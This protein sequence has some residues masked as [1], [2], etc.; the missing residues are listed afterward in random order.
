MTAGDSMVRNI[1][2]LNEATH[3]FPGASAPVILEK[4]QDLLPSLPTSIR[5]IIV[6]VGTND[7]VRFQ[8]KLTK[9]D[10]NH[11][12]NFLNQ[13]G[14]SIFISGPISTLGSHFSRIL[15]LE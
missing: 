13:C 15:S 7:I 2:F 1:V 8:L 11:L 12:I 5:R 3:C 10:F 4:L 6:H 9:I 14:K